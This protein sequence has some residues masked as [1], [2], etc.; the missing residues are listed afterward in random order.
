M[1]RALLLLILSCFIP[2]TSLAQAPEI[3][4]IAIYADTARASSEV[5][6]SP[7]V[8][9][10]FYIFCQPGENGMTC[11]EFAIEYPPSVIITGAEWNPGL[12]EVLGDVT[13]GASACFPGCRTDWVL[14]CAMPTLVVDMEPA[15]ID[16]VGHPVVGYSRFA[17]CLPGNP[18][19]PVFYGPGLCV[20]ATCLPDIDPP[21]PTTVDVNDYMHLTVRFDE[22]IFQPDAVD[23]GSYLIYTTD[24]TE[25]TVPVIFAQ[26]AVGESS[27]SIV[28]GE[29]LAEVPYL[30]DVSGLRDVAGNPAP[31]GTSID[32]SGSDNTPPSLLYGY[33]PDDHT[34]VL[35]FSELIDGAT[36]VDISRYTTGCDGCT[37]VPG[38]VTATLRP[39]GASV[40]LGLDPAMEQEAIYEASAGGIADVAGNVMNDP[41]TVY[42]KPP[43]T[44]PPYITKMSIM[45]SSI[46]E[47]AWN[48]VLDPVSAEDLANYSFFRDGS[49]EE[50]V[51]LSS[52]E[53][54]SGRFVLLNTETALEPGN[55]Y[56]LY[57]SEVM[58][59]TLNV[60]VPDTLGIS[61]PADTIPPVLLNAMVSGFY[62]IVLVFSEPVDSSVAGDIQKF[63]VYPVDSP[64][65]QLVVDDVVPWESTA[66]VQLCLADSITP[67]VMYRVTAENVPDNVGNYIPSQYVDFMMQDFFPPEVIDIHLVGLSQLDIFFNEPVDSATASGP[68]HYLVYETAQPEQQIDVISAG[69]M[70]D[71][72]R[73][74]FAQEAQ[75][76]V[77][78]TVRID[79][80]E[81]R[82]GNPCAELYCHFTGTPVGTLLDS[83]DAS[84]GDG[85]IEII[86]YIQE[87]DEAPEFEISRTMENV[88]NWQVLHGGL[89]AGDG[90][91]YTFV[92]T[93]IESGG[94]Y[95][96][97][98]E[99][100]DDDGRRVLF[101]TDAVSTPEMPLVL[102]QNS[103]NPFNPSTSIGF[104]LPRAGNVLI[105]IF[106][107]N[108]RLVRVLADGHLAGGEHSIEW[109]GRDRAGAQVSSGVYFY[110]LTSGKDSLSRKMILLR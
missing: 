105:K 25:D 76:G 71:R 75:S 58:D 68:G 17:S 64:S 22:K 78:Y 41:A 3:G 37:A 38:V 21:V 12:S 63:T 80:V 101:E 82:F 13:Y 72:V 18:A 108:G 85:R 44:F 56:T 94:S 97:R 59:T 48:E 54:V 107:V 47:L 36:A 16:I 30:L 20:N 2:S 83:W 26:L 11:A 98:V 74:D 42:F 84:Y 92:D 110:R 96:Y 67:G 88:D 46:V 93:G 106:D 81:D 60:M 45:S 5:T 79:G 57:V 66:L 10:D 65:E 35:V 102:R 61:L 62:D 1:K 27:V 33:A 69:W 14:L 51:G 24:G 90:L 7:Y 73:L 50:P 95:R 39:D 77:D 109:D 6:A 86:W 32:F 15:A 40:A 52:A 53:F 43:D 91:K 89:I 34:A 8:M 55:D 9:F 28:L 19:E 103:P 87:T 49:P 100:V 99:C 31:P 4:R 70:N 23:P 29:P 104:F